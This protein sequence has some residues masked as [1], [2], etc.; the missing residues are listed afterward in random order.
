MNVLSHSI[1]FSWKM[2]AI[3]AS[4]GNIERCW[5]LFAIKSESLSLSNEL[6]AQ[7]QISK[8]C[9]GLLHSE[10]KIFCWSPSAVFAVFYLVSQN[11]ADVFDMKTETAYILKIQRGLISHSCTILQLPIKFQISITALGWPSCEAWRQFPYLI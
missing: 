2:L 6:P 11:R 1:S 9:S 7:Q 3:Y 4:W 10:E 5:H 8:A